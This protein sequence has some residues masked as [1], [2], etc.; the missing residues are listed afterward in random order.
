[1]FEKLID[2]LIDSFINKNA[3]EVK[4]NL[5]KYGL[6]VVII[7]NGEKIVNQYPIKGT[8][9]NKLDKIFLL[10]NGDEIKLE[11]LTNYSY[12]DF[13]M[14]ANLINLDYSTSS[15]IGYV[16]SQDVLPGEVVRKDT[17]VNVEIK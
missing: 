10:S 16:V 15:T 14:Y 5:S 3:T 12:R 4:D 13:V 8:S 6:D 7:G 11:D 9:V 2:N 1:M 17:H